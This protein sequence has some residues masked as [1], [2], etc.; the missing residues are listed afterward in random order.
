MHH[1]SIP[2]H[3]TWNGGR[4]VLNENVVL[5]TIS[6][7]LKDRNR[8]EEL[9]IWDPKAFESTREMIDWMS[10]SVSAVIGP[11]GGALYNHVWTG[12]DTL[13]VEFQPHG[14]QSMIFYEGAKTLDQKYAVLHLPDEDRNSHNM[15]VDPNALEEILHE[16]LSQPLPDSEKVRLSYGWE[17]PESSK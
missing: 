10:T 17:L 15:Q 9:Y 16:H 1:L 4:E 14:F 12:K 6:Q 7:V 8:G 3:L 11:H 13:V 2:T 5:R